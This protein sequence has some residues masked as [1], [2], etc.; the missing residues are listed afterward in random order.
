MLHRWCPVPNLAGGD[1]ANVSVTVDSAFWQ[2]EGENP[3]IATAMT[4]AADLPRCRA[5]QTSVR[6]FSSG[7]RQLALRAA[8]PAA[9]IGAPGRPQQD[10]LPHSAAVGRATAYCTCARSADTWKIQDP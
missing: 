10:A 6:V 8:L 3:L 1:E 5:A 7:F 9:V 4:G 2:I